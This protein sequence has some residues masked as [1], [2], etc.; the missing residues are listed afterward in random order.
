MKYTGI[1]ARSTPAWVLDFMTIAAAGLDFKGHTLRSGG[2]SGADSAFELGVSKVE[3][4]IYLPWAG[5]NGHKSTRYTNLA[6]AYVIASEHHPAWDRL[7][8]AVKHLMAR[9]TH[10]IL[11]ESLNEPSDFVVCWTADGRAS[12]ETGQAIRLAESLNI[13]IYNLYNNNDIS[14]IIKIAADF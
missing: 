3:P 5:F 10:Q 13:P 1:G 8:D 11:G 9:N 12:G 7:S 2:A 6:Q 4:E 14:T